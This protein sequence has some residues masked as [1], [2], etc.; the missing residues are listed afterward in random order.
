MTIVEEPRYELWAD[1]SESNSTFLVLIYICCII[2]SAAVANANANAGAGC[3]SECSAD[4]QLA[5]VQYIT[6]HLYILYWDLP[7]YFTYANR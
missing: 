6:V 4:S 5:T 2:F 7:A 1:E 3:E